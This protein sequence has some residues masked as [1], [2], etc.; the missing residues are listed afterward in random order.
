V[1]H[2]IA[3]PRYTLEVTQSLETFPVVATHCLKAT[4]SDLRLVVGPCPARELQF[5]ELDKGV[6]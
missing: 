5:R 4:D 1:I 3:Q 2:D 6:F